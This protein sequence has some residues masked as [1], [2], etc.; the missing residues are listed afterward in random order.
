[1]EARLALL[2]IS[3]LTVEDLYAQSGEPSKDPAIRLGDTTISHN[4]L[5]YVMGG[6]WLGKQCED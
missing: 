1:V 6:A 4:A 3:S 5:P 2:D